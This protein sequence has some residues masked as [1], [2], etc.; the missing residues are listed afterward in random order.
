[1]SSSTR[2]RVRTGPTLAVSVVVGCPRALPPVPV[3]SQPT[4]LAQQPNPGMQRTRY[5]RR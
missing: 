4:L 5:A 2:H 1:V 3:S